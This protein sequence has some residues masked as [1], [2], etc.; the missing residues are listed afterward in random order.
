MGAEGGESPRE[1]YFVL[2]CWNLHGL[3]GRSM[4]F[5]LGG[6]AWGGHDGFGLT[7]IYIHSL[8]SLDGCWSRVCVSIFDFL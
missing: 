7:W 8:V 6:Q 2:D 4:S 1:R 5:V 3:G